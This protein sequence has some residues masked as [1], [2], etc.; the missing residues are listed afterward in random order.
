VVA[1]LVTAIAALVP[2]GIAVAHHGSEPAAYT[3][4][5]NGGG[6]FVAVAAGSTPQREC[7]STEKQVHLSG[8]DI[9]SVHAGVGL[10]VYDNPDLFGSQV[11]NRGAA[12]VEL[13][14]TYRLPQGCA[15]KQTPQWNGTAW[16]CTTPVPQDSAVYVGNAAGKGVIGNSWATVKSMTL[17]AGSYSLMAKVHLDDDKIDPNNHYY[18]CRLDVTGHQRLDWAEGWS[19]DGIDVVLMSAITRTQPFNFSVVCM[20]QDI[21]DLRWYSVRMVATKVTGTTHV[22]L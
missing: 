9:T 19:W 11:D 22:Q 18:N 13:G 14:P 21:G 3:G 15:T 5:L 6:R 10:R 8:G 17:P 1:T 7:T 2:T 4:C 20:D 16:A 12:K